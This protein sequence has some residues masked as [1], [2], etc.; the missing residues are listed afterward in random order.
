MPRIWP[1]Y[2][3]RRRATAYRGK[4]TAT[5]RGYRR[6]STVGA[7]RGTARDYKQLRSRAIK[8]LDTYPFIRSITTLE[9][10]WGWGIDFGGA[11]VK[12]NNFTA[13]FFTLDEVINPTE[14]QNLYDLYCIDKVIMTLYPGYNQQNVLD[15]GTHS[16][17]IPVMIWYEDRDDDVVPTGTGQFDQIQGLKR[18]VFTKPIKITIKPK[19]LKQ[20]YLND[21]IQTSVAGVDMKKDQFINIA[22]YDCRHYGVK[23]MLDNRQ[24]NT[25]TGTNLFTPTLITTEYHFRCR[26]VR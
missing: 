1:P 5:T 12:A 20:Y 4:Q 19:P 7:A 23:F 8:Q 14:F 9:N 25:K 22:Q 13:F 3:Y 16:P 26:G 15:N 6:A 17:A 11:G 18:R 21:T 24:S 2:V 10:S